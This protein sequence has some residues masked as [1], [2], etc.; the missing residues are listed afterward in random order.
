MTP[1]Q[2]H[3]LIGTHWRNKRSRNVFEVTDLFKRHHFVIV[4]L[5]GENKRGKSIKTEAHTD[6]FF[7]H[8]EKV[9]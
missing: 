1:S 8:Y 6:H 9:L 3:H 7:T 2:L 5:A 4:K